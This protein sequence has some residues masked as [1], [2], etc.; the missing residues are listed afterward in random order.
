MANTLSL[1]SARQQ[2]HVILGLV[3]ILLFNGC[4][5]SSL[6]LQGLEV[7]GPIYQPPI[8]TTP[9][10]T[11][12]EGR[13]HVSI[14]KGLG[15]R[16]GGRAPGHSNVNSLGIFQVDSI[17]DKDRFNLIEPDGVNL[18]E[19]RG[20]N[21]AWFV[22][23]SSFALDL[24]VP[25]SNSFSFVLGTS[26]SSVNSRH[27][28]IVGAGFAYSFRWR[29][30]AA[31]FDLSLQARSNYYDAQLAQAYRRTSASPRE[32][33][34]FEKSGYDLNFDPAASLTINTNIPSWP[35]NFFLQY[36]GGD[37]T[38][39]S[40]YAGVYPDRDNFLVEHSA[41][42]AWV[43]PGIFLDFQKYGTVQ[44]GLQIAIET[45]TQN[46]SKRTFVLPTVQYSLPIGRR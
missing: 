14:S 45:R 18:Y 29:I 32:I 13:L 33:E 41:H 17:Y 42:F 19:F 2:D 28:W 37:Q 5:A 35:V 36:A 16:L 46:M 6:Y 43:T 34:F 38:V 8:F 1:M 44:L 25:M 15:P 24:E 3:V 7:S 26:Y 31:R 40:I 23:R 11:T 9:D 21:L 22:P 27:F 30:L 20:E 10:S 4:A 39:L 12:Y